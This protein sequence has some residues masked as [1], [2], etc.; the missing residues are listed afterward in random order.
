MSAARAAAAAGS[1][2]ARRS[3][4][5][6]VSAV[7]TFIAQCE[8]VLAK[9][10][11]APPADSLLRSGLETTCKKLRDV[12]VGLKSDQAKLLQ[13]HL[14][15]QEPTYYNDEWNIDPTPD[16]HDSI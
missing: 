14:G 12:A 8:D 9:W 5:A 4:Q 3:S 15:Q 6:A 2:A 7:T 1:S 13:R 10:P 16:Y 11:A